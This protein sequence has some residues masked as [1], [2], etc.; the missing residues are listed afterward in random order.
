[1][2]N[3]LIYN[4]VTSYAAFNALFDIK[5]LSIIAVPQLL[6]ISFVWFLYWK[7][8]ITGG[9]VIV[10]TVPILI[11]LP[12]GMEWGIW[13][14]FRT[15]DLTFVCFCFEVYRIIQGFWYAS[16]LLLTVCIWKWQY[17]KLKRWLKSLCNK[18]KDFSLFND[19]DWY[20]DVTA[21]F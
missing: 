7:S 12:G 16:L 2:W 14:Q 20:T 1:M 8:R 6:F 17:F 4:S 11:A 5:A 10:V 9:T 21:H 15:R 19:I 18:N 3:V 13:S